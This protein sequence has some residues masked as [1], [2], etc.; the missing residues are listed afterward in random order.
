[1]RVI[2]TAGHVDH[3]KSTLVAALT[4]T[5]PDRLKEEQL[6]EMTI[7]LGFAWMK[8]PDGEEVGI[9]DV[10]G[11]R[12]FISN[13]L[14]GVGGIDMALLVIAADEGVMPQTREHL[15]ILD[16]LG[17]GGGIIVLTKIDLV[18]DAWLEM[19][20]S[21]V[22]RCMAGTV[23]ENAP[24]VRVSARTG[25]GLPDLVQ[26]I[27]QRLA[28]TPPRPDF[29][30]PR[31]AIDRAF[32]VSGFGTVVTG[33][34]LDG[35]LRVGDEV[36]IL[37][38]RI[39]GRIRG[40]QNH[41]TKTD[42]ALPG[43]RTAVNLSGVRLDQV[44][45]GDVL[46][47]PERYTATQRL[48]AHFRLLEEANAT[49]RHN[50]EVKMFIGAAEV[51][52]RVRLLG[53]EILRPGEVGWIQ[54]ETEAPVVAL[55]GDHYILRRP[56]PAETLGGGLIVEPFSTQ[57]HKRFSSQVIEG[58]EKL[59]YGTTSDVVLRTCD[60]VEVMTLS[61]LMGRV[62]APQH[63]I[64]DSV[65]ELAEHNH[66]MLFVEKEGD[67]SEDTL[68]ISYSQWDKL[69]QRLLQEMRYFHRQF[70]LRKGIPRE[71]LKS[72]LKLSGR[73][74]NACL[75]AWLQKGLILEENLLIH[76]PEHRIQ[77]N[78]QQQTLVDELLRAFKQSPFAPPT[79]SECIQQVGEQVYAA[80]LDLG[81]LVQVSAQV[82]FR[83]E[84]YDTLV[85]AVREHFS[86]EETLTVIQFRDR[87][88]SSR[89]YVLAFLEHLDAIGITVR[90]GD[91][92]RIS[93]SA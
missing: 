74:F 46:A 39:H 16:I 59:M 78:R 7:D 10:P 36:E 50:V 17:V 6:R 63:E 40:L 27:S 35:C 79:V 43:S 37:P 90:D 30:R 85:A 44:K 76:L 29:H 45:R 87:F 14:A 5:H 62:K 42:L 26:M 28:A 23:M 70:P 91:V 19:V 2:G 80:L 8:L 24:L 51:L 60:A 41:K 25:E 13:M 68:I 21:D 92:R 64:L 32:S 53:K 38:S 72:R 71:E 3:G 49:L 73:L 77:F 11:H 82:V 48:D 15:S 47:H 86:K 65:R 55:R 61:E 4:G 67:L 89:R 34:L 84:D 12:D 22:S 69:T 33:T 18:D 81:I 54:L 1:M 31:L 75:R 52:A 93:R 58:L 88:G 20:E 57:R 56:S 83:R 66:L 9:V